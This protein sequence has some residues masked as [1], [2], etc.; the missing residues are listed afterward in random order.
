M[1]KFFVLFIFSCF[2]NIGILA[3]QDTLDSIAKIQQM[4][5]FQEL[6]VLNLSMTYS[7]ELKALAESDVPAAQNILGNCYLDGLGIEKSY[8]EAIKWFSKAAEHG[9][10]KALNNIGY[11][12]ENGFGVEVD[13]YQAFSFYKKSALM[14][15]EI[16]FINIAKC[17]M[18]GLGTEPDTIKAIAWFEKAAEIGY[19]LAQNNAGYLNFNIGNIEKAIYWL[20][21][22]IN[23][24]EPNS[25][26]MILLGY[27]YE[28]GYGVN[29][30][31][32]KAKNL[33]KQ[34]YLLG[35]DMAKNK[36]EEY[37]I[38]IVR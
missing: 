37:D 7:E 26:A 15:N 33:F 19:S 25:N 35:N 13:L 16:A 22:A 4:I 24:K 38:K 12:Y 8:D 9:N 29:K 31:L 5:Q 3:A 30:D 10:I 32:D 27:C 34:S 23:N 6:E 2:L 36:L 20:E 21:L 1:K 28:N 11:C 14:G 17:Y 18:K